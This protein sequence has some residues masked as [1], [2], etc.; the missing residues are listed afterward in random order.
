MAG[1]TLQV[2]VSRP[3][4]NGRIA[5]ARASDPPERAIVVVPLPA[6]GTATVPTPGIAGIFELRLAHGDAGSPMIA[7][8]QPLETTAPAATVAA[9]AR[10]GR[11]RSFPARGIGPNGE[12][13]RVVL[14]PKD[15]PPPATGASYRP[16]ANVEDR[17]DAPDAPG[18][19][20]LRY[21]MHA[22]LAEHT[23]LAR[24]PVTVE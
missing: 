14:V 15:A 22:P 13:D 3:S 9:P 24:Q 17:L 12:Q 1:S 11:E 23:I 18:E 2:T 21:V 7:L 16:A 10:V 19:Y 5:V 6:S 4:A 8:R 20:E